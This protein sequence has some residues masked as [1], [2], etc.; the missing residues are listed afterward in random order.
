MNVRSKLDAR[1]P[2]VDSNGMTLS[3]SKSSLLVLSWAIAL[4]HFVAVH[5]LCHPSSDFPRSTDVG[6]SRRFF[7]GLIMTVGTVASAVGRPE[8]AFAA[9]DCFADCVKNCKK[10]APKDNEYCVVTCSD[11]CSQEDRKDGLSGSISAENGEVG[12]LGGT[13]GQGTVPNGEDRPP[14]ISLPGLDFN[15]DKGRKL[16]G[17]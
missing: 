6:T 5:G 11:Y 17:Y 8:A 1:R 13:F 3:L 7:L 4:N 15:S 16:L 9:A 12:I 2:T 14:S 10:I